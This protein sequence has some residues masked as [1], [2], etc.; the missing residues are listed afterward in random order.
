MLALEL[1]ELPLTSAAVPL[2]ELPLTSAP[3]IDVTFG[4]PLEGD[5]TFGVANRVALGTD[6]PDGVTL[7]AVRLGA[8]PPVGVAEALRFVA[9]DVVRFANVAFGVAG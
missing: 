7:P 4:A 9:F 3:G 1:R 6:A 2:A 5:V 8:T